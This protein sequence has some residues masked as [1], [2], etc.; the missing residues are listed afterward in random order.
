[1]KKLPNLQPLPRGLLR[2]RGVGI[3]EGM[4]TR[5]VN[6]AEGN[7]YIELQIECLFW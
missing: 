1:M 4:I 5:P 3:P 6:N 2:G 7:R